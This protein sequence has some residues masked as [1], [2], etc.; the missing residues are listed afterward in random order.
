MFGLFSAFSDRKGGLSNHWAKACDTLYTLH[1]DP[2]CFY[3]PLQSVSPYPCMLR[4][5]LGPI[6]S[7]D[8]YISNPMCYPLNMHRIPDPSMSS[9]EQNN[10]VYCRMSNLNIPASGGC[11]GKAHNEPYSKW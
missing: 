2:V 5:E 10:G 9:W 6:S 1:L 7:F 11:I 8:L 4:Y 3:C